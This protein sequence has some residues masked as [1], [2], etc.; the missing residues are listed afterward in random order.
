[1]ARDLT[2]VQVHPSRRSRFRCVFIG[3]EF[4]AQL[5]ERHRGVVLAPL[6]GAAGRRPEAAVLVVAQQQDAVPGVEDVED[7]ED[8]E[9][10]CQGRWPF[11]VGGVGPQVGPFV[12]QVRLRC[13]LALVCGR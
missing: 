4:F 13:A 6:R 5:T 7:V 10:V 9:E 3:P 1:M 2:A 11:V 12:E 8:V